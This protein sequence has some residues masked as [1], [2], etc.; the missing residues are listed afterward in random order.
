MQRQRRFI[1]GVTLGF[2]LLIFAGIGISHRFGSN[3]NPSTWWGSIL[4][5]AIG[6][7]TLFVAIAIWWG[8]MRQDW[9]NS[10][11]KRLTVRFFHEGTEVIRCDSAYLAG[12]ADIR[13]WSQQI[14]KQMNDNE[15]L[16]FRP[17]IT[18]TS[19]IS[20]DGTYKHYKADFRLTRIPGVIDNIISKLKLSSEAEPSDLEAM[21]AA[22]EAGELPITWNRANDFTVKKSREEGTVSA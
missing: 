19:E 7:L 14:G 10:L 11:E 5:P 2:V 17:D 1:L 3:P 22:V 6:I 15:F 8:E 9:E 4:E 18:Q 13:Q 12:E 16:H 20:Q 21:R